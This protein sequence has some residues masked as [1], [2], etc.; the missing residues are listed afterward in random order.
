MTLREWLE[1]TD[2]KGYQII[3]RYGLRISG[4]EA[5]AETDAKS[6]A[7]PVWLTELTELYRAEGLRG[8]L[9]QTSG[10]T[11]WVR[12]EPH[13]DATTATTGGASN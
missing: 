13:P 5:I 7:S 3:G 2:A 12:L 11:Q 6:L 10:E 4:T 1:E 8:L 9:A